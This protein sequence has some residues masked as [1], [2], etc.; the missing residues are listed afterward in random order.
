MTNWPVRRGRSPATCSAHA[1]TRWTHNYPAEYHGEIWLEIRASLNSSEPRALLELR[2]GPWVLRRTLRW[3]PE[4][5]VALWHTKGDDGLSI[6][7]ILRT[8]KPVHAAFRAG[9]APSDAIDINHGW[10]RNER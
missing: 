7:L 4:R 9:H 5:R 1:Q 3:G 10:E 8:D 6:P 2:W